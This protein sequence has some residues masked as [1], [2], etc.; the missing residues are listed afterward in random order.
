MLMH[1]MIAFMWC[2]LSPLLFAIVTHLK[3]ELVDNSDIMV[4]HLPSGGQLVA[5]ALVDDSFVFLQASKENLER[6]TQVWD[7]FVLA[8]GLDINWRK[9][10]LISCTE[11]DLECLGWQG[12]M[13]TWGSIYQ[14]LGYPLGANVANVQ[15]IDWIGTKLK[16]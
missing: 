13:I 4:L 12:S 8:S 11:S 5:Q 10:H 16:E 14:H 7:K 9:S 15:M 6:S 2:P 3:S 1:N